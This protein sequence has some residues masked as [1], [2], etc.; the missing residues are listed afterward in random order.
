MNSY[1]LL[2][3]VTQEPGHGGIARVST[4]LWDVLQQTS[5]AHCRRITLIPKG[6]QP[7]SAID[8]IRFVKAL[9][10]EMIFGSVDWV[11]F[12][13]LFLARAQKFVP[14]AYLRPYAVFLYS[15]EAW[16]V[17]TPK[18]EEVLR[19]ARV[20]IAISHYAARRIAAAHPDI[21]PVEICH[22]ALLP[23]QIPDGNSLVTGSPSEPIPSDRSLIQQI[24]P[25]AVLI[26]GRMFGSERHKGHDSLLEAW[27]SVKAQVPDAQLVV[28]GR[29]DDVERLERKAQHTGFAESVLFTGQVSDSALRAIYERAAIFAMPSRGEGFGLVYLEAMQHCLPC[30]GSIHDAAAEIIEDGVTGVLVDQSDLNGLVNAMAGLLENP[31]RRK[32]MGEAGFERLQKMFSFEKFKERIVTILRPLINEELAFL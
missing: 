10:E 14:R 29:G 7:P 25:N 8:K 26:V 13:H 16:S 3:T 17:L 5:G 4:L 15:F 18:L 9:A 6:F 12:D 19:Q 23:S 22:L 20:R 11:I 21:G 28:V 31:S 32:E 24:G 1:P 27:P 2:C 30:I